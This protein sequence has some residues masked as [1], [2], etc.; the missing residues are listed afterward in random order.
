MRTDLKLLRF[1][2]RIGHPGTSFGHDSWHPDWDLHARAQLQ[3]SSYISSSI[4]HNVTRSP[5]SFCASRV[6]L[7]AKLFQVSASRVRIAI[8]LL[9]LLLLRKDESRKGNYRIYHNNTQ[10][11]AAVLL[12][13]LSFQFVEQ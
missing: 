1:L 13:L 8:I 6:E 12:L 9:L 7:E 3:N 11:V 10:L 2:T 5:F 4:S